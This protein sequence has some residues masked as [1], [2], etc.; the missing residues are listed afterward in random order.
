MSDD[1]MVALVYEL[2]GCIPEA[3]A[4]NY[5]GGAFS[6]QSSGYTSVILFG[7][8]LMYDEDNDE[9]PMDDEGNDYIMTVKEYVIDEYNKLTALMAEA[10]FTG[11]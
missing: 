5:G 11:D 8:F 10:N 2:N 1:E 4:E 3:I 6:M 7:E 9:R